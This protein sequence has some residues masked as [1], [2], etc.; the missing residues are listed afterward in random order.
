MMSGAKLSNIRPRLSSTVVKENGVM[1]SPGGDGSARSKRSRKRK[2][3]ADEEPLV[4]EP[5]TAAGGPES[6]RKSSVT[7][8][9]TSSL[10]SS[11][12]ARV[13]RATREVVPPGG[14]LSKLHPSPSSVVRRNSVLSPKKL[15]FQRS[16]NPLVSSVSTAASPL[17]NNASPVKKSGRSRPVGINSTAAIS[18]KDSMAAAA[19]KIVSDGLKSPARNKAAAENSNLLAVTAP[20]IELGGPSNNNFDKTSILSG[21]GKRGVPSEAVAAGRPPIFCNGGTSTGGAVVG[22]LLPYL[23]FDFSLSPSELANNLVEGRNVP[24]P[25]QP[26]LMES[27]KLP[28]GWIKK[29]T[30]RQGFQ[31]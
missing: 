26:I 16:R 15:P 2:R 4:L 12:P 30:V 13:I 28:S 27:P 17:S 22:Q 9:A 7:T 14:F 31:I 21:D 8:P 24:G 3:F 6:H 18:E 19:P 29:V 1:P 10:A 11:K 23:R 25:G 5:A 20:V